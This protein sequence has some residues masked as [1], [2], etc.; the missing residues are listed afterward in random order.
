LVYVI[1]LSVL[2]RLSAE[3]ESAASASETRGVR[4][5]L[6]VLCDAQVQL[7][8]DLRIVGAHQRL[9]QLL[10]MSYGSQAAGNLDGLEF[11]NFLVE[12]DRP[13]FKV[14]LESSMPLVDNGCS[15]SAAVPSLAASLSVH[16]RDNAG[17]PFAAHLFHTYLHDL[18]GPPAHFIGI[19][20]GE[21]DGSIAAQS[22]DTCLPSMPVPFSHS[23][24]SSQRSSRRSSSRKDARFPLPQPKSI[25]ITFDASSQQLDMFSCGFSFSRSIDTLPK[26]LKLLPKDK[27]RSFVKWSQEALNSRIA[28]TWK[29]I[30]IYLPNSH[31]AHAD[32]IMSLVPD[33]ENIE[34][35]T[36][37]DDS[38]DSELLT[39]RA[40]FHNI[41][42]YTVARSQELL[43]IEEGQIVRLPGT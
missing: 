43:S 27:R 7:G 30:S 32:L 6:S 17:V 35:W 34:R 9:G 12:A 10:T 25:E 3:L 33:T 37:D 2:Q 4:R 11:S 14:F 19:C 39:A 1:H 20:E 24:S 29:D 18:E 23:T 8:P 31:S 21:R 22:Q 42:P 40:I 38:S 26:L 15:S 36:A 16:M 28:S 5:L 13:R 41:R